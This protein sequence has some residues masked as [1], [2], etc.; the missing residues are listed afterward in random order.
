MYHHLSNHKTIMIYTI[1]IYIHNIHLVGALDLS[2]PSFAVY[3]AAFQDSDADATQVGLVESP[4]AK[5][6]FEEQ[7]E[8]GL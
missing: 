5:S 8:L 3:I 4:A 1:Y 6:N 7:R 2:I